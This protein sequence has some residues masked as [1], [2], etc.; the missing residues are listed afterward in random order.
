MNGAVFSYFDYI[1]NDI[2]NFLL[3]MLKRLDYAWLPPV[4][5]ILPRDWIIPL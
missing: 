3:K 2:T 5:P 1:K 4:T